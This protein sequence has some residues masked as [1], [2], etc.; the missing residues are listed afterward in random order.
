MHKEERLLLS[1]D[2][3]RGFTMFWIIG[4]DQLILFRRFFKYYC[5]NWSSLPQNFIAIF[6]IYQKKK[7]KS[8]GVKLNKKL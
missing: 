8:V 4:G 3:L 2:I 5:S 1:F 7:F 6:F